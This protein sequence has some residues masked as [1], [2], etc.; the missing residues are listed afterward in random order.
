MPLL[1]VWFYLFNSC[2][3]ANSKAAADA[4]ANAGITNIIFNQAY[5]ATFSISAI[6]AVVGYFLY[7]YQKLEGQEPLSGAMIALAVFSYFSH[8]L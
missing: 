5:G 8:L 3:F 1:I 6:I 4:L 7:L 2:E